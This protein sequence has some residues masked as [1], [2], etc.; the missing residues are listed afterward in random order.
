VARFVARARIAA[1]VAGL[2]V[3]EVALV[4]AAGWVVLTKGL[5]WLGF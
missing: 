3:A 2:I 5:S 1:F 4:F